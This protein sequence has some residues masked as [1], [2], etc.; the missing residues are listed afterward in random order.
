M[1]VD[2]A[3]GYI[4]YVSNENQIAQTIPKN[5]QEEITVLAK[6]RNYLRLQNLNSATKTEWDLG[7]LAKMD[8]PE[9]DDEDE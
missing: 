2:I 8:Y 9:I 1:N 3:A 5:D 6:T 4:F 7:W